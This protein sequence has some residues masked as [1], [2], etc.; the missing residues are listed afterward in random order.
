MNRYPGG[1]VCTNPDCMR[2][3]VFT[4]MICVVS[5]PIV[6]LICAQCGNQRQ[7]SYEV[8]GVDFEPGTLHRT[9]VDHSL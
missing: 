1:A 3:G 4:A 9:R 5:L 8:D 2:H 6:T 7:H